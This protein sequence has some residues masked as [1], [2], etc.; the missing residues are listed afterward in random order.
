MNNFTRKP[1]GGLTIPKRV[2]EQV[3]NNLQTN[4]T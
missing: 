3:W 1:H 4:G 2:V